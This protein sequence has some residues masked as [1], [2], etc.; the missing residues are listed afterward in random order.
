[1]SVPT[2]CLSFDFDAL[3]L[4]LGT[5]KQSTATPVSRGEYGA[6]VGLP[7]I[8]NLLEQAAVP[9]TFFVP[10]HTAE[11]FPAETRTILAAGHEI[12][13]HGYLHERIPALDPAQEEQV[14]ARSIAA[15]V[16]VTGRRPVGFRSP[17][18]DLNPGSVDLLLAHGFLYDSS[19]MGDDYRPY[20]CRRGDAADPAGP[21]R[22]GASTPL[23]ELPV[24]WELDD[25]PYFHFSN[26]PYLNGTRT[27]AEVEQ[28]WWQEFDYM[29]Q[30]V[31]EGVFTLT[32]HPQIIGRGPRIQM[33][34]HL[35]ASMQA[36]GAR[37]VTM[38]QAAAEWKEQHPH[39]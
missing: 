24:A 10:G 25:F 26:Y 33:L 5:F 9:A 20:Y 19:M 18:W 34:A 37:F 16:E 36:A 21:Y 1:M 17:A 28:I 6:R 2:V 38:A 23:V 22:F 3:S 30:Q 39:D 11:T 15:L 32:M 7:R 4:W 35:I 27:P 29:A 8:L 12:G 13:A 14:I 31:P